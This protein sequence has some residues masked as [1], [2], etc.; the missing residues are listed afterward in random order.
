MQLFNFAAKIHTFDITK[1]IEDEP[2]LLD[3][4]FKSPLCERCTVRLLALQRI[5]AY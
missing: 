5:A 4:T 1:T 3:R 2:T